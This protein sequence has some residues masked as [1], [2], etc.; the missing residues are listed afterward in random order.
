MQGEQGERKRR[1]TVFKGR[2]EEEEE[3]PLGVREGERASEQGEERQRRQHCI[4]TTATTAE[5]R[6]RSFTHA[7]LHRMHMNWTSAGYFQ[8]EQNSVTRLSLSGCLF[9]F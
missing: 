2:G 1:E 7:F 9:P 3:E 6:G 8:S 4:T 5:R